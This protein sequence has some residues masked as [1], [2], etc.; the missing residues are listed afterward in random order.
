MM[1]IGVTK[2]VAVTSKA[3]VSVFDDFIAFIKR[4]NV[5]DLSVRVPPFRRKLNFEITHDHYCKTM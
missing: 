2:S 4:G 3:V 5:V 1:A